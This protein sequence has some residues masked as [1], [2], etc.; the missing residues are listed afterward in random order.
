MISSP[1]VGTTMSVC[2]VL[3]MPR[4]RKLVVVV[5]EPCVKICVSEDGEAG[6]DWIVKS[7]AKRLRAVDLPAGLVLELSASDNVSRDKDDGRDE[8]KHCD[9]HGDHNQA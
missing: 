3:S 9:H 1:N 8:N 4:P 2:S 6:D 7:C 5:V